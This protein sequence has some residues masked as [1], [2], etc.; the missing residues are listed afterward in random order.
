MVK[1]NFHDCGKEL[2]VENRE[3]K[4]IRIWKS[5]KKTKKG[6]SYFWDGWRFFCKNHYDHVMIKK[7]PHNMSLVTGK[8]K[9]RF[10]KNI[11]TK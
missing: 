1:C 4:T 9:K 6:F 7:L 5:K 8:T 3:A 2:S 11:K 10:N